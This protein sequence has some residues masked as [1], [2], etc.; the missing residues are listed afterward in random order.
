MHYHPAHLKT[1]TILIASESQNMT[2]ADKPPCSMFEK[3]L[4][5]GSPN[6]AL[7]YD[8]SLLFPGQHF[9]PDCKQ[10]HSVKL[11]CKLCEHHNVFLSQ[12]SVKWYYAFMHVCCVCICA[13]CACVLCE[14]VP[15][16]LFQLLVPTLGSNEYNHSLATRPANFEL[17]IKSLWNSRGSTWITSFGSLAT[18]PSSLDTALLH[19]LEWDVTEGCANRLK[20]LYSTST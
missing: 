6:E 16:M 10:P 8:E 11:Q 20:Y 3:F 1:W 9:I 18:K 13:V 4:I 2:T 5:I 7:R 12:N 15:V 17:V 14:F 19:V